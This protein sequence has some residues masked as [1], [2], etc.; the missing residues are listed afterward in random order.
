MLDSDVPN[1][2]PRKRTRRLAVRRISIESD[3]VGAPNPVKGA[4]SDLRH[5]MSQVETRIDVTAPSNAAVALQA[6]S[7]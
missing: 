3:S 1:P 7:L 6:G 5:S 4:A 2:T